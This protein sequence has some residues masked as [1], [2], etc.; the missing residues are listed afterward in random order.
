MKLNT[1]LRALGLL[2]GMVL[3]GTIVLLVVSADEKMLGTDTSVHSGAMFEIS[4]S[5]HVMKTDVLAL[6]STLESLADEYGPL[7]IPSTVNRYDIVQFSQTHL[8]P[9]QNNSLKVTVHGQAYDMHLERMNFEDID[10]G[11]DSYSGSIDGLD[12]SVAIF[13]FDRNL[14]LGSVQ[15][16]DEFLFVSPVQNRE[17]SLNTTMP[18]HIVYSSKDMK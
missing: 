18:L 12:D 17:Y 15:L 4:G 6:G 7:T 16:R 11:I 8:N 3:V 10:D 5:T 2:M 9:D 1:G 13:T 14:V